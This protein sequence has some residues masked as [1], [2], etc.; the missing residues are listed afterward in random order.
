MSS[1]SGNVDPITLRPIPASRTYRLGGVRFDIHSL[2]TMIRAGH[3]THP[4][5]REPIPERIRNNILKR[6]DSIPSSSR[7]SL[8]S[9]GHTVVPDTGGHLDGAYRQQMERTITEF[10]REYGNLGIL[11]F[12]F[13][14]SD[15]LTQMAPLVRE[16]RPFSTIKYT[17][18][19]LTNLSFHVTTNNTHVTKVV[20][21][22]RYGK[23]E[24]DIPTIPYADIPSTRH[25]SWI[26]GV[27]YTMS[28][29]MGYE[30]ERPL[31]EYNPVKL[32]GFEFTPL[33]VTMACI[34]RVTGIKMDVLDLEHATGRRPIEDAVVEVV[35]PHITIP[36]DVEHGT[37]V[38]NMLALCR[39]VMQVYRPQRLAK[40]AAIQVMRGVYTFNKWLDSKT[41]PPY[42]YYIYMYSFGKFNRVTSIPQT[43]ELQPSTKVSIRAS[44]NATVRFET[45]ADS[46]RAVSINFGRGKWGVVARGGRE[47]IWQ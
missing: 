29:V 8:S 3:V 40:R 36:R 23:K 6:A 12:I 2:A 39:I 34:C 4:T 27:Y 16:Q 42:R 35:P 46:I 5:T 11:R 44:G 14:A 25:F 30:E 7:S 26:S 41:T 19:R 10:L 18:P 13:K 32:P 17:S 28:H 43:L 1:S 24:R 33:I 22:F 15:F 37:T 45:T 20:W 47:L 31:Q 38:D 21:A 9:N